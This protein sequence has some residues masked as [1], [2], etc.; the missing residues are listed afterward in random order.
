MVSQKVLVL[1]C[2]ELLQSAFS[3]TATRRNLTAP[4]ITELVLELDSE[5]HSLQDKDTS[6][7]SEWWH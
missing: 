2:A 6:S 3:S 7:Q 5:T 1:L 4:D